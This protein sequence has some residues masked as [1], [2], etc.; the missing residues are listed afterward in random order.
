MCLHWE[1]FIFLLAWLIF[2]LESHHCTSAGVVVSVLE[3]LFVFLLAQP[4]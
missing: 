1:L 2:I 3:L 4:Q